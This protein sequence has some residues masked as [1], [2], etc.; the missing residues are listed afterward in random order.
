M[1]VEQEAWILSQSPV[2][3]KELEAV[4]TEMA[5]VSGWSVR[6]EEG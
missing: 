2:G 5:V 6:G 4:W 1:K 3:V